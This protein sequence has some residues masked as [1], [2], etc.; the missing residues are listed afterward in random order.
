M[1]NFVTKVE[2]A[3]KIEDLKAAN[4]KQRRFLAAVTNKIV[5]KEVVL[6]GL[7]KP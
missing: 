4:R 3:S 1:K 7:D 2:Q 6:N 5:D